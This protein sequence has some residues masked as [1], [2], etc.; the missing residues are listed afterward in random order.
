[1]IQI[2]V[3]FPLMALIASVVAYL[4]PD[5][6][7]PYRGAIV[8]LLTII[9]FAMGLT[10]TPADF[11]RVAT[12]P[13]VIGLGVVLQFTVMP[14]AALAIGTVLALPPEL[15][16]GLVL[17]GSC[18]GGTASNVIAYLARANVAL[19]VSMTMISSL[20]A[21]VATPTITWLLVGQTIP[22]AIGSMVVSLVQIILLPVLV[23]V[24]L[25][26]LFHRQIDRLKPL[27][28]VVA[29]TAIVIAIAIIVALNRD[30]LALAG[31]A[32]LMAIVLHN[33][34]GL[35]GGYAIPR[36]FGYD[37]T[38]SRTLA[39]EVGMQNSGLAAALALN[40]FS[41]L[42]ALPGAIF[43]VWHNLSGA[44]LAG[45]WARRP[46]DDQP[47]EPAEPPI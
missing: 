15:L 20:L 22:V 37:R 9:M 3:L 14:L 39:I 6:F 2:S 33:L 11:K 32:I 44:L 13:L 24:L 27:L 10:L 29:T 34:V 40:Y 21:V 8:P 4:A 28:P 7:M 41:P 45:W 5:L 26:T 19:S 1:M 38:T 43:S 35:A 25:N 31:P 23:G 46:T 36:L 47:S 30:D 12:R 16:V 17:L 18:P 42:A